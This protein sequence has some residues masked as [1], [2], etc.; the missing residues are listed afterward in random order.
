[1]DRLSIHLEA[2]NDNALVVVQNGAGIPQESFSLPTKRILENLSQF[3]TPGELTAHET[4]V[5]GSAVIPRIVQDPPINWRVNGLPTFG[6]AFHEMSGCRVAVGV[7]REEATL[8]LEYRGYLRYNEDDLEWDEERG[9]RGEEQGDDLQLTVFTK[10]PP[11]VVIGMWEGPR[12]F[13]GGLYL[14][15]EGVPTSVNDDTIRIRPWHVGNVNGHGAICFGSAGRPEFG[16]DGVTPIHDT[17]FRAA[18]NE[19]IPARTVDGGPMNL[20]RM[21]RYTGL[22]ADAANPM[23]I[24]RGQTTTTLASA[25]SVLSQNPW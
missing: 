19:D 23:V 17:F 8:P 24:V 10:L 1:M 21:A 12:L 18:F 2:G 13:V 20:A 7:W 9:E 11:R 5:G 4:A 6:Y 14:A 25:L 22:G 16:L 15:P 3:V